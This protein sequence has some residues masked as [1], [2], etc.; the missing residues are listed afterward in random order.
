M[1]Q[2]SV[3]TLALLLVSAAYA[4]QR[5]NVVIVF[6]DD[7]GYGDPQVNNPRSRV[8]TPNI[9]ALA[10]KGLRFTDAHTA[11]SV[12]SPSR[13]GL[14]TGR[15]P[16]RSPLPKGIVN[17]WGKPMIEKGRLTMAQMLKDKGYATAAIGKWH[18]GWDWPLNDGKYLSDELAVMNPPR[19]QWAKIADRIDFTREIGEGPLT[20][21]FDYYFGDDLPNFPPYVFIE[22]DR[23]LGIPNERMPRHKSQ[24][25]G[26]MMQTWDLWAVQ[27]TI[28]ARAVEWI[29]KRAETPD[30]P[31]FLYMPL[32]GPHTPIVPAQPY[33][34][35]SDAGPYG[36]WV[37]QM[38]AILGRVIRAL[39]RGGLIEN[40]LVIFSSDNGSPARSGVGTIG[41][42]NTVT[43]IYSHVPN[44]PWRGLKSDAWEAGHHVPLMMRWD[45]EI[46]A[47][48]VA[49][50]A[51]CLTDVFRTVAEIVGAD[52]P[53]AAAEDSFSLVPVL[54][55]KP[56]ERAPVVHISGSG[57]FAI[58]DGDWK[59]ILGSGSGGFS[60]PRGQILALDEDGPMQ[61]Y[62]LAEDPRERRN[63]IATR[64]AKRDELLAKLRRLHAAS[65]SR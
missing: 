60:Q 8:P 3:L 35:K 6:A 20:R 12:C 40:T 13:Y 7:M 52:V 19:D 47:G 33:L 63:L 65:G 42:T 39:E 64:S 50:D 41:Q 1:R 48:S 27:P 2:L 23:T 57:L 25:E 37:H 9:D 17:T 26:P 4:Q 55:G 21:G 36:D 54:A 18:L 11:S 56:V 58:R 24:R 32:N 5:P 49:D 62:N 53:D 28:T 51:V 29:D 45:G 43:E 22:N 46:A 59:L 15:Y 30:E 16:W 31:F 14:L 61:L 34:G 38:D 44:A 10:A